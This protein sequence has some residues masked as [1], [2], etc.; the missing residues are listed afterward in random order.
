MACTLG[1][2]EYPAGAP[3]CRAISLMNQCKDNDQFLIPVVIDPFM[4]YDTNKRKMQND[5]SQT[6]PVEPLWY[7]SKIRR[8]VCGPLGVQNVVLVIDQNGSS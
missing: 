7:F 6:M 4:A 2:F 8:L 3:F 5:K 1:I